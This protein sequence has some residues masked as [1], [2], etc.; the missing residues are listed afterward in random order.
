M[1]GRLRA[2]TEIINHC[3]YYVYNM[4]AITLLDK[5]KE[6]GHDDD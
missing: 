5:I 3:M 2:S 6:A 1:L 4:T